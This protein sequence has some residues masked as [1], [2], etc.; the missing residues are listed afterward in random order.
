MVCPTDDRTA[1]HIRFEVRIEIVAPSFVVVAV[2][3]ENLVSSGRH[4]SFLVLVFALYLYAQFAINIDPLYVFEKRLLAA[5]VVKLGCSDI[6]VT[7]N[8]LR[9]P[10]VDAKVQ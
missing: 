9:H 3:D 1:T 8:P 2:T 7:G 5:A 6:G 10:K 4:A